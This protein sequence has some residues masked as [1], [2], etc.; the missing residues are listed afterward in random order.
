MLLGVIEDWRCSW[1]EKRIEN[2]IQH[3]SEKFR[4]NGRNRSQLKSYKTGIF[5]AH[6]IN[7]IKLD[8]I[9]L[10]KYEDGMIAKF[11]QDYSASNIKGKNAKELYF[12]KENN[13]WGIIAERI[14]N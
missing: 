14:R 4:G 10:L 3:Y 2:Y 5:K 11:V 9:I 8:N 6:K 12:V 7:H 13:S 1:E